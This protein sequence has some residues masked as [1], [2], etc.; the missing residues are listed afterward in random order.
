MNLYPWTNLFAHVGRTD[1]DKKSA[2]AEFT[3]TD[4]L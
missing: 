1:W 4:M 3:T 2:A